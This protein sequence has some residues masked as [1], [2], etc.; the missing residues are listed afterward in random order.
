MS[1]E[2]IIKLLN[3]YKKEFAKQYGILSIGLAERTRISGAFP[4]RQ[5]VSRKEQNGMNVTATEF[6]N[7]LGKYL[8]AAETAPVI[9]EKSGRAKS[10]LVSHKMY[11]RLMALEDDYW[12]RRTIDA[13]KSGYL[14]TEKTK[15][16]LHKLINDA[17]SC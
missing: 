9:I 10:V 6:K 13:E 12:A 11:Q 16:T 15:E 17:E 1:R 2:E 3:E 5:W 14:G 4:S 8:D 7:R